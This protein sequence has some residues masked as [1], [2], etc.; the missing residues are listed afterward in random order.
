MFYVNYGNYTGQSAV[1]KP[2]FLEHIIIRG[3]GKLIITFFMKVLKMCLIF[4]FEVFLQ[5]LL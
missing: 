1:I 3:K 5:F 2:E 4:N